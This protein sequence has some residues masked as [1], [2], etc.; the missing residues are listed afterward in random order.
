MYHSIIVEDDPMVAYISESYIDKIG[1]VCV[2]KIFDNG[3]TA[4]EYLKENKVDLVILDIYMPKLN[5]NELL[6]QLRFMNINVAVI[7]I[8]AS[9]EMLMLDEV[10]KHGVLDYLVKPFTFA[11]FETSIQKF[12]AKCKLIASKDKVDQEVIDRLINIEKQQESHEKELDKGLN[13]S[14]LNSI[15]EFLKANSTEK[16]TC[17]SLSK[18]TGLSKVTI[19][20]YLNYIMGLGLIKSSIDYETGGRPRVIYYM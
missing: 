19:R 12:K 3:F 10:L 5:G 17:A 8:T 1:G 4:L 7:M 2:D 15:I 9:T 11:R 13:S 14:T 6:R 16:H 20:R 18:N